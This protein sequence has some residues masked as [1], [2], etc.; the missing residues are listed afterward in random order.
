MSQTKT[1]R[2]QYRRRKQI[3]DRAYQLQDQMD[4]LRSRWEKLNEKL[5]DTSL[6]EMNKEA[7]VSETYEWGDILA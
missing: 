7:G 4:R 3:E 6:R 2:D 5:G 1:A